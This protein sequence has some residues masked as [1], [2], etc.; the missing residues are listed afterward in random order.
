MVGRIPRRSSGQGRPRDL[1]L[2]RHPSHGRPVACR[3]V[4][5]GRTRAIILADTHLRAHPEKWLPP[6]ADG[7]LRSADVILHAGDLVEPVVLERLGDYAPTHAV[8]GNNDRTLARVLPATLVLTL[9]GVNVALIHDSG[10]AVGRARRMGQR[11]P[12][13]D[14]VIFGHSHAPLDAS[15]L[16][17]QRLFNPGS[18]TQRRSQP[19]HTLGEIVFENGHMT[20]RRIIVLD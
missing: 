12:H 2:A 16:G 3:T 14:L 19:S 15:G 11:F 7:Y 17:N 1:R 18:P 13:A 9:E 6:V 4:A 8:L 10:P 20:T 5:P